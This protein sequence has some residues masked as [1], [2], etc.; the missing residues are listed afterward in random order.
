MH[1]LAKHSHVKQSAEG[2][3]EVK[4][5][6]DNGAIDFGR[7]MNKLKADDRWRRDHRI[8]RCPGCDR[9]GMGHG[10]GDKGKLK[11]VIE[12]ALA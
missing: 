11:K 4:N 5:D 6:A 7:M 9:S 2:E 8:R 12:E 10:G 3:F 1:D